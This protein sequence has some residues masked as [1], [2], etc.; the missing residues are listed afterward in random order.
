MTLVPFTEWRPDVSDFQAEVTSEI[1]NV[2]PRGDGYGPF[3]DFSAY[4][5][6]LPGVCR[7]F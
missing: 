1:S 5:A 3:P 2:L 4:T 6:G 7:G